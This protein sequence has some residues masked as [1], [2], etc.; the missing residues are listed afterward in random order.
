M[1]CALIN[2]ADTDETAPEEQNSMQEGQVA[3]ARLPEL[4]VMFKAS[5]IGI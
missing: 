3:L 4:W 1:L 5:W 2:D